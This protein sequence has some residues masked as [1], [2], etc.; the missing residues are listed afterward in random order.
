MM[1]M[2][3]QDIKNAQI[4]LA[5]VEL[6]GT[7]AMAMAELQMKLQAMLSDIQQKAPPIPMPEPNETEDKKA[8]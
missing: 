1:E 8:S 5:R 6:K 3:E 7:E 4:F 2:T